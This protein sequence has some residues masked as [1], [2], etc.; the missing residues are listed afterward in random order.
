MVVGAKLVESWADFFGSLFSRF[1]SVLDSL[2]L[3]CDFFLAFFLRFGSVLESLSNVCVFLLSSLRFHI[4]VSDGASISF[5]KISGKKIELL[6]GLAH[7]HEN[8]KIW[9]KNWNLVKFCGKPN[10]LRNWISGGFETS[11]STRVLRC[12]QYSGFWRRQHGG[13]KFC[14]VDVINVWII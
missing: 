8:S 4:V 9:W 14:I 11:K 7:G 5:W 1:G 6:L 10:Y 2:M 13:V 3:V 12:A